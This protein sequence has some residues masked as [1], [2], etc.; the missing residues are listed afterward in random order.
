MKN[1]FDGISDRLPITKVSISEVKDR[2]MNY[3]KENT[4]GK[5]IF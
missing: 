4:K 2:N 1:T 3:P 5:A